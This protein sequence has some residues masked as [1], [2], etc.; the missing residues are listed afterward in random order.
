MPEPVAWWNPLKDTASTD[1]VHRHND[2]FK[3]LITTEQA[4]DY[5]QARV[6]EVLDMMTDKANQKYLIPEFA[7]ATRR[8]KKD[9]P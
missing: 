9:Q 7:D 1:P 8:L 5:A 6:N 3:S 4:E 2:G